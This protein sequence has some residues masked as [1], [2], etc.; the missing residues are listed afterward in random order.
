VVVQ[1]IGVVL[2][3][4]AGT[5]PGFDDAKKYAD[6]ISSGS[7]LFL[8]DAFLSSAGIL[9]LI[10]FLTGIRRLIR[11]AGQEWEWAAALAFG[12]GLVL[13]AIGL[14]GAAV[15]ASAA[16]ASTAGVDPRAPW[17]ATG[18]IFTVIFFPGALLM[19]SVSYIVFREG[20]LPRWTGWLGAVCAVLNVLA[21]VP[22]FGGTGSNG[23][24]GL[25]P[26]I[27]GA[28]PLFVWILAAS[29]TLA[30]VPEGRRGATRR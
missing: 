11:A 13:V 21:V 7:G 5:P 1:L 14:A 20:I 24:L 3:V 10:G 27:L 23:P 17:M 8:W 6:F 16:I 12:V 4:A 2:Y 29:V 15:E 9:V 18:V 26:I 30:A 19:G 28:V 22:V 25:L